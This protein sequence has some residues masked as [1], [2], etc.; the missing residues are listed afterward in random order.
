MAI[1]NQRKAI[2]DLY[3]D[4]FNEVEDDLYSNNVNIIELSNADFSAGLRNGALQISPTSKAYIPKTLN[5]KSNWKAA[6]DDVFRFYAKGLVKG[7]GLSLLQRK[8]HSKY[9]P[10]K[11]AAVMSYNGSNLEILVQLPSAGG[12]MRADSVMVEIRKACWQAFRK[13]HMTGTSDYFKE[14]Q[15]T[16]GKATPHSHKG[17]TTRGFY[18]LEQ[19][20]D[21][22]NQTD[23][24]DTDVKDTF[25]N[26]AA[27]AGKY[28]VNQK[29]DVFA[30]LKSFLK[31]ITWKNER[32]YDPI[33]G[34]TKFERVVTANVDL[35]NAPGSDPFDKT[36]ISSE[37]LTYMDGIIKKIYASGKFKALSKDKA[38]EEKTSPS[39]NESLKLMT[40]T[41]VA[42]KLTESK[43]LKSTKKLDT[44]KKSH[45][46]TNKFP[47][48]KRKSGAVRTAVMTG[49]VKG[50]SKNKSSRGA[51]TQHNPIALKELINAALP[52]EL[53][54]QMQPPALR[55]RTGRFRQ[56]AEVTNVLVGPR[57]GVE[58]EYTYMRDPYETFEPGGNMGSR[59]RDPRKLIGGSV[60]EIAM[61]LTGNKFIRTRRV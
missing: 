9:L 22:Y 27:F 56:S 2:K 39:Y 5:T 47:N 54:Q 24:Q 31:N 60:R 51:N 59:N 32:Y 7:K 1:G 20:E 30:H 57:G 44:R 58:A 40:A 38:N 25:D 61:R 52:A 55:N 11:N 33:A 48:K 17:P 6:V 37:M 23:Y 49:N 43:V 16:L 15:S 53:L 4:I 29:V 3:R 21:R 28:G 45:N 18:G 26:F 19:M 35:K 34:K 41:L 46:K 50:K 42:K 13:K 14:A 12:A 36:P 8:V 10:I